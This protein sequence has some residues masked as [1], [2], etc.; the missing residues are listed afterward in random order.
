M[1]SKQRAKIDAID[2]ELVSLFE[3]RMAVVEEVVKIKMEHNLPIFDLDRETSLIEKVVNQLEN[4]GFE[5]EVKDFYQE[6][7]RISKRYQGKIKTE[8]SSN[9]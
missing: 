1:L 9:K 4:T 3:K 8:R 2:Q 7:M 6:L 5:D